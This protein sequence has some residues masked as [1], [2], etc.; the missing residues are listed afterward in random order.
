MIHAEIDREIPF[1]QKKRTGIVEKFTTI[2]MF[3]EKNGCKV[4]EWGRDRKLEVHMNR[5]M[6]EYPE[7]SE[8]REWLSYFLEILLDNSKP[9]AERAMALKHLWSFYQETLFWATREFTIKFKSQAALWT[10]EEL[11][12]K[13]QEMFLDLETAARDL[14]NLKTDVSSKKYVKQILYRKIKNWRDKKFGRNSMI[15][16]I[17]LEA[18]QNNFESDAHSLSRENK[19]EQAMIEQTLVQNEQ[20]RSKLYQDRVLSAIAAELDEEEASSATAAKI[21]KTNVSLWVVLLLTYGL[22]LNQSGTA[23]LLTLNQQP[24]NQ[25]TINRHINPFVVKLQLKLLYE[26]REEI[27]DFWS[28]SLRDEEEPIEKTPIFQEWME[29]KQKEV[30]DC[31][32]KELNERMFDCV[33]TDKVSKLKKCCREEMQ[34]IIR[35]KLEEWYRDKYN[36]I[37][38]ANLLPD[39]QENKV[40]KVVNNWVNWM[41]ED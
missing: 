16:Q 35:G 39:A 10:W 5:L 3:A 21:G 28:D 12:D 37:I 8:E 4:S 15:T 32:K 31:L 40:H 20:Y 6:G 19:I 36:I 11:F 34:A 24:I 30:E 17:N 29:S 33:V 38:N 23:K 22:N 9:V 2:L 13:A 1:L 25:S 14:R 7:R 18:V 26:F 41:R 27:Q